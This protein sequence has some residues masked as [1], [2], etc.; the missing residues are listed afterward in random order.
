M[1]HWNQKNIPHKG[2]INTAMDDLGPGNY[3]TC[4]M[5]GNERVRYVHVMRHAEYSGELMVGCLCAAKMEND[6]VG[7]KARDKGIR[8]RSARRSNWLKR[9]WRVSKNGNDFLNYNGLNIGVFGRGQ[10]W[11][12]WVNREV[13][14]SVYPTKEAAKMA[15]FDLVAKK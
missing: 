8:A 14:Q 6:Y 7:A 11:K 10:R 15:L 4:E 1:N 3:T 13:F 5:C 12:F 2:W 9:K